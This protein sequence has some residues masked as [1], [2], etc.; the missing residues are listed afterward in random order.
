MRKSSNR[1]LSFILVFVM[2]LSIIPLGSTAY[3]QDDNHEVYTVQFDSAGGSV[4][5][6][7]KVVAEEKVNE[8]ENPT[9]ENYAFSGWFTEE[10]KAFSF[11]TPITEDLVL[12]AKWAEIADEDSGDQDEQFAGL[13]SEQ[14]LS[15]GQPDGSSDAEADKDSI[16]YTVQF[17]S[18]GGS[19]V[20]EQKVVAGEKVNEPENPTRENYAFSGWFTEEDKAFSFDTPITEDLVLKAKWTEAEIESDDPADQ[21]EALRE[22]NSNTEEDEESSQDN[23]DTD[24]EADS[25]MPTWA[26]RSSTS[27]M[28]SVSASGTVYTST[29]SDNE[30]LVLTANTILVVDVP[31]T[32][33]SISGDYALTIQGSQLLMINS[34]GYGIKVASINLDSAYVA[35]SSK[36]DGI[37][38]V[39]NIAISS[40]LLTVDAGKDGV[41]SSDG[42]ITITDSSVGIDSGTNCAA[43]K[44]ASGDIHITGRTVVANGAKKGITAEE[45]SIYL[46]GNVEARAGGWAIWAKYNITIAG[47]E[48]KANAGAHAICA[49]HGSVTITGDVE[50]VSSFDGANAI[51]GQSITINSGTVSADCGTNG[52][53]IRALTGDIKILSGTVTANGAKEGITAEEG[54]IYLAGNVEAGASGWAIWANNNIDIKDGVIKANGGVSAIS[55]KGSLTIY[56]PLAVTLPV[57]G[58][59]NGHQITNANDNVAT[60]AV[61][62]IPKY[63]VTFVTYGLGT[64]PDPQVI[65]HGNLVT[66]PVDPTADGYLFMGWYADKERTIKY[67]FSTPVSSNLTLYGLWSAACTVTFDLNGHGSPQPAQQVV[68]LVSHGIVV[69]EPEAPAE[70][71]WTFGGWYKASNCASSTRW[72]FSVDSEYYQQSLTLYAK[73]TKDVISG[74]VKIN[75]SVKHYGDTL[76][77]TL[78]GAVADI[79]TSRLHYQWQVTSDKETWTNVSGGTGSSYTTPS[80]GTTVTCYR[81]IVTADGYDRQLISDTRAVNP[82]SAPASEI[83][84]TVKAQQSSQYETAYQILSVNPV[85]ATFYNTANLEVSEELYTCRWQRSTD[86]ENWEYIPGAIGRTYTLVDEDELCWI[87]A[88]VTAL[89]STGQLYSPSKQVAY[90]AAFYDIF[91]D[92]QGHGEGTHSTTQNIR[93]GSHLELLPPYED[94]WKFE[95]W[96]TDLE[97]TELYNNDNPVLSSFTLYAKWSE[98]EPYTITVTNDGHGKGTASPDTAYAG[99]KITLSA[100]PDAGYS[101]KEWVVVTGPNVTF[102]G[103]TFYMGDADIVIQ[104]TFEATAYTITVTDDGNGTGSAYPAS[105]AT[106]TEVVLIASPNS[107]YRLKEWQVVS[108]GVTVSENKFLIGTEDVVI[109]AIFELVPTTYTVT[110][111]ANGHGISPVEQIVEDGNTASKPADPTETGWIFGGWYTE[112]ACSNAFDFSTPITADITLYAKWTEVSVTPVTYTVTFDANGHGTAPAAQTVNS[113]EKATEPTAPTESGWTFGGWYKE[114]TCTTAFDFTTPI[115]ADITLYAKWTEESVTPVTYTVTF[116]A[117]GHGTAPAAQTVEDG[118][119]A[120][121]PADPTETGWIFG[122]WYTEAACSNAFDF[123]TPITANITLYAKWTEEGVT[124]PVPTTYTVTFD[125]NGHGTAPAAQTVEDGNTATKP[126]D[127]METGWIFGGWY[128]DA[129]C[130][131]AFDF[132]TPITAD[133]TLYAKWTEE[134]V[135]PVDITYTVTSGSNSTW[136][137]DSASTVTITVKRSE[138]DDTC[139]SHFSSLQIDG[140]TLAA[141]DYEAKSGSTVI[142]LK[143]ATLQKL[144][145]GSHTVTINFDDGKAETKLTVKAATSPTQPETPVTGDNSHLGLWIS[146]MILSMVGLG[147]MALIG[148]KR[149]YAPKH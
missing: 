34:A 76:D 11:D 90:K 5:E 71:G 79:S 23:P 129:T 95:G 146:M 63:T 8:P 75:G 51:C 104:A 57:N 148:R 69:E 50:A 134:S 127:P 102:S 84:G 49:S 147:G 18:T 4:V 3:A 39:Q 37:N 45:G 83:E 97:C 144:S 16:V 9:R 15:E 113:G 24:I 29:L 137:K 138:A 14:A 132:S 40:S 22:D 123:S 124:P 130:S 33:K 109:K 56:S 62:S 7:Q 60:Y 126:A 120:T 99:D 36:K 43:I 141:G 74:S 70:E 13:E 142:T 21:D 2:L 42:S 73:W 119:T 47:G 53:A 133:I 121:K 117:N 55:A 105:G 111:D 10:D 139:F 19:V 96:Y 35:I 101:F 108:G 46:A 93:R 72:D 88:E 112:A 145:T 48:T 87:R 58:K 30:E 27:G 92:L 94:G 81:V 78:S 114:A 143:A 65:E 54:S 80:S 118:N 115:T 61:I 31:R 140:T 89:H 32:L 106:G 85:R 68:P 41:Y 59:T 26:L 131:V 91:Y 107:G 28:L 77:T 44:A 12:K 82:P 136:T 100:E 1:I 135:T 6:E 125:A 128:Q 116:D 64:T 110:F 38:A 17:D 67:D 149:R 66:K 52:A 122:G 25:E 103:D 98:V 20:E 86:N